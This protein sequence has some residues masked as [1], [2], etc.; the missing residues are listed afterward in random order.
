MMEDRVWFVPFASTDGQLQSPYQPVSGAAVTAN[1]PFTTSL[2]RVYLAPGHK[3]DLLDRLLHQG[4][5]LVITSTAALGAA[6]PVDRVHYLA[7]R[8]D[9]ASPLSV[10][11]LLSSDIYLCDAYGGGEHLYVQLHVQLIDTGDRHR[12]ALDALRGLASSVGAA[13][14]VMLPYTALA[15]ETVA[16][17]DALAGGSGPRA[18]DAILTPLN[19][20]PPGT[21]AEK[22]LQLG[23]WVAFGAECDGSRYRLLENGQLA[24]EDGTSE[25]K[26]SYA[27]FR[28]DTGADPSFEDKVLQQQVAALL[29]ML[30]RD[31]EGLAANPIQ[32]ALEVLT[33]IVRDHRSFSAL[34]TYHQLLSKPSRTPEEDHRIDRL[35]G[36]PVLQPYLPPPP[37]P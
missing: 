19:L 5:D 22:T 18:A 8:V 30:Q 17:V 36:H 29:T 31:R 3:Q 6:A 24:R 21:P 13:F 9:P 2:D 4:R 15:D 28:I 26:V 11:D 12:A 20:R 35:A 33:N 10:H 27:V 34:Q 32:T 1:Q 23:R 16:A 7:H 25:D 37:S 14:P